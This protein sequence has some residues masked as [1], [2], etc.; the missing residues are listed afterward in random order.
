MT[1]IC[2]TKLIQNHPIG[3][4]LI[5]IQQELSFLDY[6]E[7]NFWPWYASGL[8]K[9]MTGILNRWFTKCF[10]A[11][12]TACQPLRSQHC[13]EMLY[14]YFNNNFGVYISVVPTYNPL[15]LALVLYSSILS[16]PLSY[17]TE[18]CEKLG[19]PCLGKLTNCCIPGVKF[20]SMLY[21]FLACMV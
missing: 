12:S 20:I 17:F 5:I 14:L 11:Y 4:S 8:T 9:E 21:C 3:L 16:D 13:P 18:N 19:I 7:D 2:K 10:C 15:P 1:Q 6:V